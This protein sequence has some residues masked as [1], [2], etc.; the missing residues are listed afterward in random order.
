MRVGYVS[1]SCWRPRSS[2]AGSCMCKL[3]IANF[4]R[5]SSTMLKHRSDRV[6]WYV[7]WFVFEESL[8]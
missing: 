1:L 5:V 8:S 2:L 4:R 6:M 3:Y 7:L